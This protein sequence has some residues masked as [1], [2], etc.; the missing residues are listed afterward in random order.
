MAVNTWFPAFTLVVGLALGM[1]ADFLRD[2]RLLKREEK[3]RQEGRRDAVALRRIEFQRATLLELLDAIAKLARMAGSTHHQDRM[4]FLATGDWK[5][6]L[7][8]EE[9]NE[10]FRQAQVWVGSL[11]IRV[12][13]TTIRQ[14]SEDMKTA[15]AEVALATSDADQFDAMRRMSALLDRLD[16][17]IG[18]V[19]RGL[20]TGEDELLAD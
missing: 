6:N 16:A 9:V 10:G 15:C 5:K 13:D 8:T 3:A 20:D 7:L 12:H 14:L 18:E 1:F 11:Y 19:L 2:Q 4:S 17:R